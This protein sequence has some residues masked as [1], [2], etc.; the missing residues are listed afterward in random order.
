M[1][2]ELYKYVRIISKRV[3]DYIRIRAIKRSLISNKCR[4]FETYNYMFPL[5]LNLDLKTEIISGMPH[6]NG[7][8]PK[9]LLAGPGTFYEIKRGSSPD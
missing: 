7:L 1:I 5:Q 9:S 3:G 6:F 2:P 8:L 4:I